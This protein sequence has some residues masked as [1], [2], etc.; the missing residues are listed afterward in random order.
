[1]H[2]VG[3][4]QITVL[5]PALR[6]ESPRN[7]LFMIRTADTDVSTAAATDQS[8]YAPGELVN[9]HIRVTKPF[10][11][12]RRSSGGI[13]GMYA[14]WPR[15]AEQFH[16]FVQI[17][18]NSHNVKHDG[19]CSASEKECRESG[20]N[21]FTPPDS[22]TQPGKTCGPSSRKKTW[23]QC[24]SPHPW[25]PQVAGEEIQ[26]YESSNYMGLMIYAEN[27]AGEKVGSWEIAPEYPPY[28]WTPPDPGCDGKTLMHADARLKRFHHV[29]PFR[30]PKA[31]TGAITFRALIKHGYTNGGAF[32]WPKAPAMPNAK[33]DLTLS[34]AA[35]VA[36][37]AGWFV[38]QTVGA[39]CDAVCA[40][41]DGRTCDEATL[42]TVSAS[43]QLLASAIESRVVCKKPI[44]ASCSPGTPAI[45]A[46][47]SKTCW[48]RD[49]NTGAA[50]N[51]PALG[52]PAS[53]NLC[54]E[55]PPEKQKRLCP[56]NAKQRRR[57]AEESAS[58]NEAPLPSNG[59][60][61]DVT[62]SS[63]ASLPALALAATTFSL[64]RA[65]DR[66]MLA[67]LILVVAA[68]MLLPSAHAHNW[69]QKPA[70]RADMASTIVPCPA[71]LGAKP[72]IQLNPGDTFPMEWRVGHPGQAR[73]YFTIVKAGDEKKLR[74][75]TK[76]SLTRYLNGAPLQ[77]GSVTCGDHRA[78][79]CSG[80]KS[81]A[82]CGGECAVQ[83]SACVLDPTNA[84]RIANPLWSEGN[85]LREDH[86]YEKYFI[87]SS[88]STCKRKDA[89]NDATEGLF[90]GTLLAKNNAKII[91]RP[92]PYNCKDGLDAVT[93]DKNSPETGKGCLEC[94]LKQF[95][96]HAKYK[97]KDERAA[98]LSE[99]FPWIVSVSAYAITSPTPHDTGFD[100]STMRIPASVG[101]GNFVMQYL[102][103][104]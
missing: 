9:I 53:T 2:Y 48:F 88:G 84:Y 87:A 29:F 77:P 46:L 41:N 37:E 11:E 15:V 40:A 82:K 90:R 21:F 3:A 44:I 69:L 43:P 94:E 49:T 98:Y 28:F 57:L 83:G 4:P 89:T 96:Y 97:T 101:S 17:C 91:K 70:S 76:T 55:V 1:M 31:G 78:A 35:S 62:A 13:G 7:P 14:C 32:F 20:V 75:A 23:L 59:A 92:L 67:P 56:C 86:R 50:K 71:K 22:K 104:R 68:S 93:R 100:I 72:H 47:G 30:A 26:A 42:K 66:V 16:G 39:N 45:S 24:R 85:Y 52:E 80:C 33:D 36:I 34:E 61:R 63:A 54:A 6:R 74:L 25:V 58:A 79:T 65:E 5:D 12:S 99:Q 64:L 60:S 38:G 102:W 27:D 8:S 73:V 95:E 19:V 51:C 10:T 103:M 18:G 81:L